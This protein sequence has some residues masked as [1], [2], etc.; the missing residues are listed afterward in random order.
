M[1]TN[2]LLVWF[3][4]FAIT[5]SASAFSPPTIASPSPLIFLLFFLLLACILTFQITLVK[6]KKLPKYF[7]AFLN[8]EVSFFVLIFYYLF[9]VQ[10][11]LFYTSTFYEYLSVY[12]LVFSLPYLITLV[13]ANAYL[14]ANHIKSFLLHL[15]TQSRFIIPFV[16]VQL[17]F[18]LTN[19]LLHHYSSFETSSIVLLFIFFILSAIC[20]PWLMATCW[21]TKG[22]PGKNHEKELLELCSEL[23]FKCSGIRSWT[24]LSSNANA[25]ILG[26]FSFS[27]FILFSPCL[28]NNLQKDEIKAILCHEIAH[29]KKKHLLFYPI[30]I[31][32]GFLLIYTLSKIFFEPA[33]PLMD[34]FF[35]A[36]AWKSPE[37]LK[38][39][40][41]LILI[42]CLFLCYF[43]FVFGF[44][45]RN[46]EREADMFIFDTNLTP[47]SL[48]KALT[49]AAKVNG[50]SIYSPNWHHY[51]IHERVEFI[52]I[53]HE[54]NKNIAKH[55]SKILRIKSAIACSLITLICITL[56]FTY[57]TLPWVNTLKKNWYAVHDKKQDSYKKYIAESKAATLN[58]DINAKGA[59]VLALYTALNHYGVTKYSGLFEYYGAI[60]LFNLQEKQASL[61]MLHLAWK[62]INTEIFKNSSLQ[63]FYFTSLSLLSKLEQDNTLAIKEIKD[64]IETKMSLAQPQTK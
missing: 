30:V 58:L 63:E 21:S 12:T 52:N 6:L 22:L 29:Q 19:D 36:N 48:I 56:S 37:H 28:L 38:L 61:Q 13:A 1:F 64:L 14:E 39:L 46:F 10:D 57:S 47:E 18:L 20:F 34:L 26:I 11:Y 32:I 53:C 9:E 15:N 31:S 27:R 33:E 23:D 55:K 51:S 16:I 8:A 50:E 44:I 54:N 43:R 3:T 25:A 62:K 4:L 42:F 49:Q 59:E 35:F 60:H 41:H 2:I 7:S 5:F 24:Q 45:S 17:F 40:T